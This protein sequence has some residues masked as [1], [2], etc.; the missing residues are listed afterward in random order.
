MIIFK[1]VCLFL[2]C[3]NNLLFCR[4]FSFLIFL[5]FSLF[6]FQMLSPF[7]FSPQKSPI[8]SPPSYQPTYSHSWSW[9]APILGHR[10]FTG[11]RASI[12]IDDRLGHPLLHLQLEPKNTPCVFFD[13]WF[14]CKELWGYWLVHIDVFLGKFYCSFTGD[15]VLHAM[16]DWEHPL[17]YLPSTGRAPQEKV[18]SGSCPQTSYWHLSYCLGLVVVYGMDPQVGQ[19]LDGHFFTL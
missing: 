7:L 9:H 3:L 2:W 5:L 1:K 10:T 12:P 18:L 13:W 6:A 4:F 16:D 15:I 17:L 11:P 19:F 8:P 14:S